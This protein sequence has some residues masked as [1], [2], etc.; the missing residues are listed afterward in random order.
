MLLVIFFELQRVWKN[1]EFLNHMYQNGS[2]PELH[3]HT[4]VPLCKYQKGNRFINGTSI[5]WYILL[6]LIS[7]LFSGFILF[8][9][10]CIFWHLSFLKK[11]YGKNY[12]L[13]MVKHFCWIWEFY[14]SCNC[15][16][17]KVS[18]FLGGDVLKFTVVLHCANAESYVINLKCDRKIPKPLLF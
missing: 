14:N 10:T 6:F 3:Y 18:P 9:N 1:V 5:F 8:T 16:L 13:I 7:I 2:L 12:S 15:K 17:V 11:L 4:H